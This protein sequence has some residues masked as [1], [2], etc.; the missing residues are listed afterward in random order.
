M[1]EFNLWGFQGMLLYIRR[2]LFISN[3][4]SG[5]DVRIDGL[6]FHFNYPDC[7]ETFSKFVTCSHFWATLVVIKRANFH[8][9]PWLFQ[10]MLLCQMTTFQVDQSKWPRRQVRWIRIEWSFIKIKWSKQ[11]IVKSSLLFVA[12]YCWFQ[13]NGIS[14][15]QQICFAW[16]LYETQTCQ[17]NFVVYHFWPLHNYFQ[18]R[19][20]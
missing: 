10:G 2:Q 17:I 5:A 13:L 7:L 4:Q 14:Y 11:Y 15:L 19:Q 20:K 9:L 12:Q 8:L 18:P 16:Q 1:T 6:H 3:N